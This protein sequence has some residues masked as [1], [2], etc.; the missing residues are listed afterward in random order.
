VKAAVTVGGLALSIATGGLS[1]GVEVGVDAAADAATDVAA[2]AAADATEDVADTE[3]GGVL[4][5]LKE[6]AGDVWTKIKPAGTSRPVLQ[7]GLGAAAGGIG[8]LADGAVS[9]KRRWALVED[10]AW[11]AATGAAAN[12]GGGT[13]RSTLGAGFASGAGD[14]V[15]TDVINNHRLPTSAPALWGVAIDGC[16]GAAGNGLESG[17]SKAGSPSVDTDPTLGNS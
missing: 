16:L 2:D 7:L 11:G 6:T 8:N 17:I 3:G 4:D 14:A 1:V 9:G 12:L 15:G 5:S 13:L 10:T